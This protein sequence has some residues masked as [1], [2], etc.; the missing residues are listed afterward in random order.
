MQQ[1]AGQDVVL[2]VQLCT[3]LQQRVEVSK[4][5]WFDVEVLLLRLMKGTS[6]QL[7]QRNVG[8]TTHCAPI[9]SVL[10]VP[11]RAVLSFVYL[12]CLA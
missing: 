12:H 4:V 6:G 9:E 2:A 7:Q 5:L 1:A 3:R 11:W 10:G 8:S